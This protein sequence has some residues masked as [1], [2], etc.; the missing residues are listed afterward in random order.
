VTNGAP[1]GGRVP[2]ESGTPK[3]GTQKPAIPES[4]IPEDRRG[5]TLVRADGWGTAALCVVA[6]A[7]ALAPDALGG[8]VAVVSAVLFV[9]GIATFLWGFAVGVGRSRQESVTMG[10]LFLLAGTAPGRVRRRMRGALAIQIAVAVAVAAARPYTAVAFA[11]LAPMYGLG[12]M[13]LWGA[14]FGTFTSR[15]SAGDR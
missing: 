9:T 14:R 4:G 5:R 12:L 7:G 8:A 1:A 6:V 13:A 11:V 10:G 3:S 15:T 2:P